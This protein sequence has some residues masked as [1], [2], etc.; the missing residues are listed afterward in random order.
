[1]IL[2]WVT[3]KS[4]KMRYKVPCGAARVSC[5]SPQPWPINQYVYKTFVSGSHDKGK[6]T[7]AVFV[8]F[9]WW[10][11]IWPYNIILILIVYCM[12]NISRKELSIYS[13]RKLL[14]QCLLDTIFRTSGI[15][16]LKFQKIKFLNQILQVKHF[17]Y[18]FLSG[19]T[20]LSM[21]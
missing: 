9:L 10:W 12:S 11:S 13:W 15:N 19:V 8:D 7:V 5:F 14:V 18:Y 2:Q 16:F 17:I 3:L 21:F 4:I 6:D 20:L 1:M